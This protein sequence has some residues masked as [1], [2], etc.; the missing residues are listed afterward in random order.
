M[1]Q[2]L[3][4]FGSVLLATPGVLETRLVCAKLLVTPSAKTR[5]E[6]ESKVSVTAA[7]TAA[8][9]RFFCSGFMAKPLEDFLGGGEHSRVCGGLQSGNCKGSVKREGIR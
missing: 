3:T 6:T 4:R 8:R 2:G 5:W 7:K 9:R 1:P